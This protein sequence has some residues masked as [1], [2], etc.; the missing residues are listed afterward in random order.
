MGTDKGVF[1]GDISRPT[2][3]RWE[4]YNQ[5]MPLMRINDLVVPTGRISEAGSSS[6]IEPERSLF[7]ATR[8]RGVWMVATGP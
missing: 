4:P 2:Y 1:E 8:G 5:G 6:V 7:A 3:D